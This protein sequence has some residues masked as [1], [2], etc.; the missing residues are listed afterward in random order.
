MLVVTGNDAEPTVTHFQEVAG[1]F[2]KALDALVSAL[3]PLEVSH[4]TTANFVRTHQN[5]PALFVDTVIQAVEQLPELQGVGALDPEAWRAAVQF[6]DAFRPVADKV[7]AL[8]ARLHFTVDSKWA[9][10]SSQC[11]QMYGIAKEAAPAPLQLA[12]E[13]EVA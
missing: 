4:A 3:P 5:V 6:V 2:M 13:A 8:G 10:V 9:T 1:E 7:M 11:L 12:A